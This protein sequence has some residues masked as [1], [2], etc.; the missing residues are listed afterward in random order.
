ME[1]RL[2][3]RLVGGLYGVA[4]GRMFFGESMFSRVP[5]A[6]KVALAT[7]VAILSREQVPVIDC[8]QR[9]AHL[10]S[11]GGCEVPRAQF[12]AH[13]RQVVGLEPVP[14]HRYQDRRLNALL[15]TA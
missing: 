10:A 12:C 14:W 8:Q 11:L 5:D 9:T 4:L 3:G 15:E 2:D 13:L 6:S 7:L 1:V